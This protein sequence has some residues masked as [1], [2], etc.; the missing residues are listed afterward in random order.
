LRRFS[1]YIHTA[2]SLA[3]S[4]LFELQSD[5]AAVRSLA[6]RALFE[7]PNRLLVEVREDDR[8]LFSIDRNGASWRR[9]ENRRSKR[10]APRAPA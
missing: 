5:E 9:R 6:E 4:F 7:S 10:P 3:P 8:L 1:F 2:Q